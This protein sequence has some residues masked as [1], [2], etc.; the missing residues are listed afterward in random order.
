MTKNDWKL[1]DN[2]LIIGIAGQRYNANG[3]FVCNAGAGKDT[4]ANMLA[5]EVQ[6]NP[7]LYDFSLYRIAFADPLKRVCAMKTGTPLSAFYEQDLK[8]EPI[9]ELGG[10]TPRD[11]AQMEGTTFGRKIYGENIWIRALV[12]EVQS[13]KMRIMEN[14]VVVVPDVRFPNEQAAIKEM[15]GF[16]YHVHR[17]VD[18]EFEKKIRASHGYSDSE[19]KLD[20]DGVTVINNNEISDLAVAATRILNCVHEHFSKG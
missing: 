20:S 14:L 1:P 15:G 5:D 3:E 10:Y 8:E 7:T 18:S 13:M 11:I 9:P 19:V 6:A 12:S 16:M 2:T 17:D 4:L